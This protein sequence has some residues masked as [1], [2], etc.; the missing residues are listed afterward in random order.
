MLLMRLGELERVESCYFGTCYGLF[1]VHQLQACALCAL[2]AGLQHRQLVTV[3]GGCY[4]ALV[5]QCTTFS[6]GIAAG[7]ATAS[8]VTVYAALLQLST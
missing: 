3:A 2:L 4:F 5:S 6:C 1:G 8:T 7:C